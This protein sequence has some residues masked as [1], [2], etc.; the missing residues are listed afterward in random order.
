[1][2]EIFF[3]IKERKQYSII[4]FDLKES[5]IPELL[6]TI[7]PPK[8]NGAKGVVLS[9]RGPIW[10]YCY[11]THYYHPTKFVS[12]YDPRLNGA[13]IVESHDK[14]YKLGD[15]LEMSINE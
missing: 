6:K 14:D 12:T 4:H 15:I 7:R 10:L 1:M 5:I 11:L 9:G 8:A 13:I 2:E 3:K